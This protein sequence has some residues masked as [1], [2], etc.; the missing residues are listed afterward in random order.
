MANLDD[1]ERFGR[2]PSWSPLSSPEPLITCQSS[3]GVESG[4]SS[5]STLSLNSYSSPTVVNLDS[6]TKSDDAQ[7][8]L[9]NLY[10]YLPLGCILSDGSS[11]CSVSPSWHEI[12]DV[13]TG[14]GIKPRL[15]ESI[16]RLL[17]AQWIRVYAPLDRLNLDWKIIRVYI[18]P[19][20][21]G[22][23]FIDRNNKKLTTDLESLVRKL[24]ISP[25]TWNGHFHPGS[26]RSFDPWASTDPGSLFY[27]FNNIPSPSPSTRGVWSQ[28]DRDA[29]EG[30]MDTQ[31]P[32]RGLKTRLHPFQRR[33]A[34]LMLQRECRSHLVLDP[35]LERR[36]APNGA[37]YYYGP[38][39][40]LFFRNAR[41]YESCKGGILAETMGLGKTVICMAL[42]LATKGHMPD[43]PAEY[44]TIK[45]R[46]SVGSLVD[47]AIA[48]MNRHSVPWRSRFQAIEASTGES[49][50]NCARMLSSSPPTYEI[51]QLPAR[52]NRSTTVPPPK[53]LTLTST[54][55]IVVP[56]NLCSQ[57]QSELQKHVANGALRVLVMDGPKNILPPPEQLRHFDVVLFSRTRFELEIRDGSDDKGRRFSTVPLSCQCPYIG[58]SR[59]RDCTCLRPDCLYDSPLKH[60]H[61]LRIIIDEGHFFSASNSAAATVASKLVKADHR[62]VV[63]G[64]PAKD[65]L[66]VEMDLY[67][68]ETTP[69][70]LNDTE[71]RL[72]ILE[73]RKSFNEKDDTSGA[74]ASIGSLV[75][76]FL[77]IQPW[78][79]T[80]GE[81]P[82]LWEDYIYRHED[83]KKK[84]FAAF[85]SCLRQT[86][87]SIVVKTQPED[88]ERDIE[89]P[90]L[91]HNIVRLEPSFYDRLTAN[92]F[93]LV[94]TA[95]AVTSERTDADYLFHKN[96]QK[97]RYQLIHNL[98]QSAFFWTGFSEADVHAAVSHGETYLAKEDTRCSNEDRHLLEECIKQAQVALSSPG[99]KALSTSHEI[100]LFSTG[101]PTESADHWSFDPS[102][103]PLLTGANQLLEAQNHV[104]NRA[105]LRD[106]A[107]G[108]SGAG[109]RATGV[110]RNSHK[111]TDPRPEGDNPVLM[112]L[113]IPS[114]S[115][116][117]EPNK[118]KSVLSGKSRVRKQSVLAM[119]VSK[120]NAASGSA[121]KKQRK[122]EEQTFLDPLSDRA[123]AGGLATQTPSSNNVTELPPDSE[124]LQTQICGSSAS[125]LSYLVSKILEHYLDEKILVF[126]DGD[127]VAYYIA[128]VLELFHVPHLIY[129]KS[130]TPAQKSNYIVRFDQETHFR[131]LLMDV[132]QAALGLNL[133]SASRVFFVN[134]VCRP[135]IEA[136]AIKRAHR[137][138]QTRE[139][140]IWRFVTEWT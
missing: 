107:E 59:T 57:W 17:S 44:S 87:E 137:I 97:A 35:R 140:R 29:L 132:Q 86:L 16:S 54:T 113:G 119:K 120:P 19:G 31:T 60:L 106:P 81:R 82:A 49:M 95:N 124:L 84:T 115:V 2:G 8:F 40:L 66:G 131:V 27:K 50:S 32:L 123:K 64:T 3:H 109:I 83:A 25:N 110:I 51:P 1:S 67:S 93:I 68:S 15:R 52:F 88:V 138:G 127:N 78:A 43:I 75:R 126:Y 100:G 7:S 133:A 61:F 134:P 79:P 102:Q 108:L 13:S 74:V 130:L 85:S 33:S 4:R 45:T 125:K 73:Q 128:Q 39:D 104:N 94:L 77:K 36:F 101:W 56:R 23:R 118:K 24:D 122:T 55:V 53:K 117:G 38:R 139:V 47:M 5:T 41:Y 48:S 58:A 121:K 71:Q 63:S 11:P 10:N 103:H 12:D 99:W 112:K 105:T 28:H 111:T 89:L 136:Q 21:V 69:M 98:R 80:L 14:I 6:P 65:L 9:T 70:A 116:Q 37:E 135:H 20:D 34:S 42:I 18:L 46:S 91:T 76:S 62:W 90:P 92:L 30:L 22:H 129:A 114:S 26:R 72:S 96:S